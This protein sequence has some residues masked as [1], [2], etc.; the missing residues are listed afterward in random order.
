MSELTI[1]RV[2]PIQNPIPS[3]PY[4][5]VSRW[6]RPVEW[7]THAKAPTLVYCVMKKAELVG[8]YVDFKLVRI[9]TID[10]KPFFHVMKAL[11]A[12][13]NVIWV[14]YNWDQKFDGEFPTT[15]QRI[16]YSNLHAVLFQE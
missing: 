2:T 8:V 5:S 1:G 6:Q 13:G 15:F 10:P 7:Q 9:L 4:G 11:N 3:G 12:T 16:D 14:L